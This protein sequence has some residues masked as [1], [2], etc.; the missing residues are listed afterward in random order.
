[1]ESKTLVICD[2]EEGYAQALALY[3][4][5]RTGTVF[6]VQVYDCARSKGRADVLIISSVCSLEER[7]QM[8]AGQV[9]VITDD[10]KT[11]LNKGEIPVYKYQSGEGILGEMMKHCEYLC[12]GTDVIYRGRERKKGKVIGVFSPVHRIGKTTYAL[13]LGEKLAGEENVLYL[14]LEIYGGVGGHFKS[15]G[16]SL[17]DLLY[18]F[19][20][21]KANLGL[22]LSTM[23]FQKGNLDYIRPAAVSQ[24]LKEVDVKEL[25]ELIQRILEQSI[26]ETII[27]DIDEGLSKVYELLRFC[28]EIHFLTN[29]TKNSAAKIRQFEMEAGVL[30]YEDV[31]Q[32]L[33]RKDVSS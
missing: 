5:Q 3:I 24:D 4:M 18:Y 11:P 32:K 2:P 20:Q 6:Q 31:L 17:S 10:M 25:I 7:R 8:E 16:E 12:Y 26:Y 21:E 22:L 13:K 14:N 9:F 30:G 23:V 15:K 33:I 28:T 27:L 29:K 19:R 1:M